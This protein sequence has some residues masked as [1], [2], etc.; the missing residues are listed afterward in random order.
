VGNDFFQSAHNGSRNA[1]VD[2]IA[3]GET[4]TWTWNAAGSHS[5][6]STGLPPEVFPSSAIM[7]AARSGYA[8]AFDAPGTYPYQCAVHGAAMTGRVVVLP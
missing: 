8:L 5:I 4:V 2:T 6:Q 7:T 1:A 3:V